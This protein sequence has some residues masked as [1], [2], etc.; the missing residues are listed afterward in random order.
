MGAWG[1]GIRQD[2]FVCD[3]IEDFKG[4][5]KAGKTIA[6]ATKTV[7]ATFAAE[8][9]DDDEGPLFWIAL[10]DA[11]WTY[12]GLEP[13]VLQRVRDDFDAERGLDRWREDRRALSRRRA[14]IETFITKISEPN[15]RPKKP[16]KIVVRPPKFAAGDC[17]SVR[18]ENGQYTAALVLVADHSN[19]EYG[20]N[21][22][23]SLD[24]LAPERPTIDDF[25][26]RNWLVYSHPSWKGELYL[27]WHSPLRFRAFKDRIGVVGQIEILESDP[28]TSSSYGNWGGLGEQVVEQRKWDATTLQQNAFDA[29]FRGQ[30]ERL[31][32]RVVSA[33]RAITTATPPPE[34]KILS[35]EVR[36]DWDT[37]PVRVLAMSDESPDEVYFKPPFSGQILEDGEPLI[38]RG[39]IDR[40][41]Y[42]ANGVAAFERGA[43]LLCEWFGG[44]WEAATGGVDFPIPTYIHHHHDEPAYYD[45]RRRR[46]VKRS[47]VWYKLPRPKLG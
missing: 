45:L 32:P 43:R 8:L 36:S 37:F 15:P 19:V 29:A 33:L 1:H 23:V 27:A 25:R 24:Y 5:M 47:Q 6:E 3:V 46:W 11:Q 30:L 39:T 7:E 28:K 31:T 40:D 22:I 17:L 35:F 4:L 18:L 44:C 41:A 16:P 20:E 34:M 38:P 21:L 42:D 13:R 26:K 14:A 2:D 10:A 12:G 9:E